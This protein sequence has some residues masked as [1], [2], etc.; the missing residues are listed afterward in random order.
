MSIAEIREQIVEKV[1]RLDDEKA[2]Y[3]VLQV[4]NGKHQDDSGIDA[5]KYRDKLFQKHDGLLKRLS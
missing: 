1:N 3:E 2:L 5:T 4:L